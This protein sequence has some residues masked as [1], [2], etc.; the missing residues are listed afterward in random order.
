MTVSLTAINPALSLKDRVA[1]VTGGYGVIGGSLASSL[2]AVGSRV[3]IIGRRAEQAQQKADEIRDSGGEAM[4]VA[5]DAA[6]EDQ[7]RAALAEIVGAWKTIDILINAAGG[8]V[9]GSR[10]DNRPIF[11][12]PAEAF[13]QVLQL[14][15][16]G[17]VI[18]S[19]V[20]G[21]VMAING[22]G[23]ILNIS[24]MAAGQALSGVMGYSIA[25]AG[26]ENFTR[27]LSVDLARR[28]GQGI[29]VNAIAPG[30][31]VANQNRAV[32]LNP[33]GSLTDRG[34]KIIERTPMGRFGRADEL[35]GPALWL[36]SDAASFV[37]G[38][39]VPVDGGFSAFSG[40]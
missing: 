31:F 10:S 15:L 34:A 27:W 21:E 37:T 13:A 11:D 7:V 23:A 2:A 30:F 32:L 22:S 25:K 20:F 38:V 8:N 24:S 35:I 29:R 6:N 39:V 36:C 16:H 5:A 4:A 26:I 9:A 33:D 28:Y 12:V 18:P 1:V 19:L 17:T 40:I 14:N 3:A